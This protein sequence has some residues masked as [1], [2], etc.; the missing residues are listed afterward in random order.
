MPPLLLIKKAF[1]KIKIRVCFPPSRCSHDIANTLSAW[2]TKLVIM[3]KNY[4]RFENAAMPD[5]VAGKYSIPAEWRKKRLQ[6]KAMSRKAQNDR[7]IYGKIKSATIR[8]ANLGSFYIASRGMVKAS[9]EKPK[10]T[11]HF[12]PSNVLFA[13]NSQAAYPCPRRKNVLQYPH[14]LRIFS[15]GGGEP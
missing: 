1:S 15:S 8:F 10:L 4:K 7:G 11:V 13:V 12:T 9:G 5:C 6:K 3:Q 2:G 14:E